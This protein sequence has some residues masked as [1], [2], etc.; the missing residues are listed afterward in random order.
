M[1]SSFLMDEETGELW[2]MFCK[3]L[4]NEQMVSFKKESLQK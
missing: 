2:T 1:A 4:E 3:G